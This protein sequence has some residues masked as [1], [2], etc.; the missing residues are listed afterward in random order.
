MCT[1]IYKKRVVSYFF[2]YLVK[3]SRYNR[4]CLLQNCDVVVRRFVC[5]Y[6]VSAVSLVERRGG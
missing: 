6:G 5:I 1:K 3:H 4:K 2:L